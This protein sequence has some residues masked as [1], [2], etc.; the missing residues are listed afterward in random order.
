MRLYDEIYFEITVSGK[1][2][3]VRSFAKYIKGG[4]LDD[5]IEYAKDYITYDDDDLE[6]G[7]A[8]SFRMVFT[9]DDM[10]VEVSSFDTDDFLDVFCKETGALDVSG[11][12][13]DINDDEYRFSSP[14]GRTDFS[15]A[16][17]GFKDELDDLADE[18][19]ENY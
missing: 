10:G 19:Y 11:H 9:N 3:D 16:S 18:E 8:D 15:D 17:R 5:F 2:T 4:A 6:A 14:I 13:Y 12:I 1:E 7:D